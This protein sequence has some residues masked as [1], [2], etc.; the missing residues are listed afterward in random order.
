MLSTFSLQL[1]VY[2]FNREQN[3]Q[4]VAIAAAAVDVGVTSEIQT[5]HQGPC[6]GVSGWEG[7]A[8]GEKCRLGVKSRPLNL[9]GVFT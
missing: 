5:T 9:L 2:L 7:D 8:E 3:C 4:I 1:Q 6:L